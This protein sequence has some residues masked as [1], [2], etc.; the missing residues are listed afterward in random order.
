MAGSPAASPPH[1]PRVA[2]PSWPAAM[3]SAC[4]PAMRR[5]R[6][7]W[8]RCRPRPASTGCATRRNSRKDSSTPMPAGYRRGR[9][10]GGAGTALAGW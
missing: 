9:F 6:P 8:P 1:P 4:I 10:P 3:W 2:S 5:A 7:C